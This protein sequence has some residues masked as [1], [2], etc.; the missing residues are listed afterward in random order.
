MRLRLINPDRTADL[1]SWIDPPD[2]LIFR[3]T[4]SHDNVQ[5]VDG[6]FN[7]SFTRIWECSATPAGVVYC[8]SYPPP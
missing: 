1:G 8:S 3:I 5:R 2:E 6:L 7:E 4:T